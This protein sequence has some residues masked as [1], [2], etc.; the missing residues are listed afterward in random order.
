MLREVVLGENCSIPHR[1][2]VSQQSAGYLIAGKTHFLKGRMFSATTISY[3]HLWAPTL[4]SKDAAVVG[5]EI[6]REV[7][8]STVVE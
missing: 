7:K 5:K 1:E 8:V 2:E 4:R 6:P 3:R